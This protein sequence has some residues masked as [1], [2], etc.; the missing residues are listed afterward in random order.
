MGGT[1]CSD[2]VWGCATTSLLM[3]Q[4]GDGPKNLIGSIV[5]FVR[6]GNM[7]GMEKTIEIKRVKRNINTQ[8]NV[9]T[10]LNWDVCKKGHI[11]YHS[12]AMNGINKVGTLYKY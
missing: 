9:G 5:F 12:L 6:M 8:I 11:L 7:G 1:R 3:S 2:P 4:G 10:Y